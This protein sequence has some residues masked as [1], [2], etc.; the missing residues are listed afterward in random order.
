MALAA[1][2]A[3][4]RG[5]QRA[6]W[7]ERFLRCRSRLELRGAVVDA[8]V[9][10]SVADILSDRPARAA[11]RILVALARE[12]ESS[13]AGWGIPADPLLQTWRDPNLWQG[14]LTTLRGRAA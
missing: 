4:V 2:A 9:A 12:S 5:S 6:A 1:M 11:D 13:S 3:V 14:V 8:A 10:E 7:L